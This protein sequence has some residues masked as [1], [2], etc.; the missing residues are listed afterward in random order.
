MIVALLPAASNSGFS[1]FPWFF[2]IFVVLAVLGQIANARK[3]ARAKQQNGQQYQQAPPAVN[4]FG[5]NYQAPPANFQSP[6]APP[7]GYAQPAQFQQPPAN[8]PGGWAQPAPANPGMSGFAS[9]RWAAEQDLKR[10][11]TELDQRR[12]AGQLTAEQYEA[13]REAIFRNR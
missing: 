1:V 13:E 10:L 9:S 7:N 4:N 5:A 12:R 8:G 2:V 3:R 11:L 6:A